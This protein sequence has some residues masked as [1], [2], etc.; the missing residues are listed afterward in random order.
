MCSICA[1]FAACAPNE[2]KVLFLTE[3]N[4]AHK[5]AQNVRKLST[6]VLTFRSIAPCCAHF[7][8]TFLS[9]SAHFVLT[10][11]YECKMSAKRQ[12]CLFSGL[13]SVALCCALLCALL[14]SVALCCALLR[15]YRN[16]RKVSTN[17]AQISTYVLILRS[18]CTLFALWTWDSICAHFAL[19]CAL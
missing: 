16:E 5:R 7:A 6:Y 3:R 8:L 14:R 9:L 19:C 12:N 15:S 11:R 4:T 18:L 1:Q 10:L 2:K 17:L 13:R